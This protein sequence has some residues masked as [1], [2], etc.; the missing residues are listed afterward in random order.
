M[1]SEVIRFTPPPPAPDDAVPDDDALTWAWIEGAFDPFT[2]TGHVWPAA[3]YDDGRSL[4][5]IVHDRSSTFGISNCWC[6]PR[7]ERVENGYI[8]IIH[9]IGHVPALN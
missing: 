6:Q 9:S 4:V 7:H 1:R 2:R 5:D 3:S 8:L